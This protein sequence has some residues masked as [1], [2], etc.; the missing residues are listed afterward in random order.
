MHTEGSCIPSWLFPR[1]PQFRRAN[2]H[3]LRLA[4][5]RPEVPNVEAVAVERVY[6]HRDVIIVPLA[7]A[8]A[9]EVVGV[10]LDPP[11]LRRSEVVVGQQLLEG[12]ILTIE[13]GRPLKHRK[14]LHRP[15]VGRVLS[16]R[17]GVKRVAPVASRRRYTSEPV[18][19]PLGAFPCPPQSPVGSLVRVMSPH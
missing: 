9:A 10:Y 13:V 19:T 5:L 7:A 11:Y 8:A 12:D 4:L 3:E 1:R 18:G 2:A 6:R 17:V 15:K 16:N 14:L